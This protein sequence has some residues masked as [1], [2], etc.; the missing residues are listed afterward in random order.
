MRDEFP[1]GVILS[2]GTSLVP[3]LP[4][5]FDEGDEVRIRISSI[6][7]LANP[8]VRGKPQ[9]RADRN[10]LSRTGEFFHPA[11]RPEVCRPG[12]SG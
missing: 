11:L 4:F 12:L 5:T 9:S 10:L 6:G 7:Q 8:V 1:A 3:D 2:T